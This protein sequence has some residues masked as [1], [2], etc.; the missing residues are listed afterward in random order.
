VGVEVFGAVFTDR[1][2]A[3]RADGGFLTQRD[4][5]DMVGLRVRTLEDWRQTRQGPL[6]ARLGCQVGLRSA[7]CH[8]ARGRDRTN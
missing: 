4:L 8:V 1:L 3:T 5:V 2:S 7:G 6:H